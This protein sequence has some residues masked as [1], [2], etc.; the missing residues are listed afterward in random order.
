MLANDG[1]RS[2]R[3][4][5]GGSADS[6]A[7][8]PSESDAPERNEWDSRSAVA[9]LQ[10]QGLK[11]VVQRLRTR[12]SGEDHRAWD[13]LMAAAQDGN[14]AAYHRLLFE[15]ASWLRRYVARRLPPAIVDDAV[16]DTLIAVH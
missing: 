16:Q 12:D 8:A 9:A 4:M 2:T 11:L 15:V 10:P 1:L 7:A 6:A 3:K 5:V 14:A 13:A